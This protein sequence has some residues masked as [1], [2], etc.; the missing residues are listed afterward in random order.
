[1]FESI[2]NVLALSRQTSTPSGKNVPHIRSVSSLLVIVEHIGIV[3]G[4]GKKT[5]VI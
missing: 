5:Q 1:M 3:E 2:L 4:V